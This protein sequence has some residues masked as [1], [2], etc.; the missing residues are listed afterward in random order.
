LRL[1]G[2]ITVVVARL[3]QLHPHLEFRRAGSEAAL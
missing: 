1:S 2:H 3:G